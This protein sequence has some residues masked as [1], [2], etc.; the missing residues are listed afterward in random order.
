MALSSIAAAADSAPSANPNPLEVARAFGTR[1]QIQ[2]ISL[3]PDG[4]RFAAVLA[5][6]GHAQTV[7]IASVDKPEQWKG[8]LAADGAPEKIL[9]CNWANDSQII[10]VGRTVTGRA[11]NISG[12]TRQFIVNA[13]GSGMRMLS[14][15]PG[16]QALGSSHFGGTV[17]DWFGDPT[18]TSILATREFVPETGIGTLVAEKRRGVGVERVDPSNLHRSVIEPPSPIAVD[19]ISDGVGNVRIIGKNAVD[20]QGYQRNLVHY[21]FRRPGNRTWEPLSD[22]TIDSQRSR[23]FSPVAVDP[24]LNIAYGF[25]DDGGHAALFKIALDGSDKRDLVYAN[26]DVDVDGLI[27]IGRKQRVVGASYA[28]DIRHAVFFDP[29][30]QALRVALSKAVPQFPLLGFVD[31]SADE[32]QLLLRGTSD[33][34]PG[35]FMVFDKKTRH[36]DTILESRPMLDSYKLAPVKDITYT[37]ADGTAVPAYL[38]LP[39]GSDGKNLPAIVLPHGGPS[40]RDEWGFDWLAQFF[41]ARGYAVLQPNYRGSSGYGQVWF[42]DNGF[43]SWR[44]AIGD[45]DDAGRWLIKQGVTTPD[46]LAIVGWSYGGYAALQSQV[47]D[48]GLFKAVVAIAPVTDLNA[49]REESRNFSNFLLVD[50]FVGTGAH[51]EEGSPA[52]HADAFKAPVLMFHGDIDENVSIDESRLMASRLKASGKPVELVEFKGFD[53][54][55]EDNDI[56]TQMLAKADAFLRTTM[57]LAQ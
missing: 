2:Q 23:G 39:V 51:I 57:K 3:S 16:S 37:A 9:G 17:L 1:E 32:N 27:Q 41:A 40:A 26:P 52:R 54:Y 47:L 55:L 20:T 49:Y 6:A 56:R 19:Y 18:G 13:D 8:V 33:V 22:V 48:P 15:E 4:T 24:T 31:S 45:V 35:V 11:P 50:A 43:K 12:F 21:F 53:H 38:T 10:C 34:Q 5:V 28:T 36:L 7:A 30:L 29:E 25:D 42:K 44:T 46:H 14:L